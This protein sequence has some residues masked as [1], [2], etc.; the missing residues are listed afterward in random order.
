MRIGLKSEEK[1][2]LTSRAEALDVRRRLWQRIEK[3]IV[4]RPE[5]NRGIVA[6][7]RPR[8][9]AD[10]AVKLRRDLLEFR[11]ALIQPNGDRPKRCGA[12]Y[13]EV[14][15]VVVVDV[16]GLETQARDATGQMRREAELRPAGREVDIDLVQRAALTDRRRFRLQIAV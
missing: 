14:A 3:D 10:A 6:Q 5:L 8:V 7:R 16:G 4:V 9:S 12:R 15:P 13:D 11:A 1:V 2:R